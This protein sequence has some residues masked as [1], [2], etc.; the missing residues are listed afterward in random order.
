MKSGIYKIRNTVNG[1]VYVGSAVNINNRWCVHRHG[2]E[3]GIHH[4]V[5]LQRA[6]DKYGDLAF[7]F[8]TLE[9]CEVDL[10][11]EREQWWIESLMAATSAG[12]NVCRTAGNSAGRKFSEEAREKM[13]QKKLGTKRS[14]E[15]RARQ[16]ESNKGRTNSPETR[17]KISDAQAGRPMHPNSSAAV[18]NA[19]RLRVH[20]PETRAKLSA[21]SKLGN[22]KRKETAALA[23]RPWGADRGVKFKELG[24][25]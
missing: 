19:N 6:W 24:A 13:R 7:E 20:S 17:K 25:V 11:L 22:A 12:Y 1:K 2:L 23:G 8:S 15:S 9:I 16:S 4:S 3:R 5:K 18:A 10:L 21:A 14:V